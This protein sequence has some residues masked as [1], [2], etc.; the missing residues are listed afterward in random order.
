MAS[1]ESYKRLQDKN[2]LLKY[3]QLVHVVTIFIWYKRT[4][5]CVVT[6]KIIAIEARNFLMKTVKVQK[7]RIFLKFI[8]FLLGN[9]IPFNPLVIGSVHI[10]STNTVGIYP[11][12]QIKALESM[13]MSKN[14]GGLKTCWSNTKDKLFLYLYCA[15]IYSC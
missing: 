14:V 11:L 15:K 6:F 3:K 2:I 9:G 13:C 10:N 12:T 4:K 7:N 1:L 5:Y 8:S